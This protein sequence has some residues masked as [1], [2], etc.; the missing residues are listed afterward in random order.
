MAISG[1]KY[2]PGKKPSYKKA[3]PGK[4]KATQKKSTAD[5]PINP[6]A[7]ITKIHGDNSKPSKTPM[8]SFHTAVMTHSQIHLCHKTPRRSKHQTPKKTRLKTQPPTCQKPWTLICQIS[9]QMMNNH[10]R[11]SSHSRSQQAQ[12]NIANSLIRLQNLIFTVVFFNFKI[13]K[14]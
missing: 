13:H 5:Q 3:T 12:D 6:E 1:R 7:E 8:M 11:S 9:F 14:S 10:C 4:Q 2:N